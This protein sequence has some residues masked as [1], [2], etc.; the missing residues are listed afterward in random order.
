MNNKKNLL[1][2]LD[3]TLISAEPTTEYDFK[4]NKRKAKK[5]TFHNMDDYYI[6]FERPGLQEF[7]K[8]V[9]EKYNVS[10]WTAA[11]KEYGL[12]IIEKIL[13]QNKPERKL[14]FIMFSYHCD[15]SEKKGKGLKDLGILWKK[16][17]LD[18]YNESNT[19]IIDDNN[20]VSEIN[21]D[22]CIHIKPFK[23]LDKNSYK[24]KELYNL[25]D[26]L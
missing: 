24:D 22:R 16:F 10:V 11:S 15:I 17:K 26:K 18:G 3:E 2:D 13:L 7:L 25:V 23:F 6:V 5:F 14:D 8:Y 1:L 21:K 9:F 19:V 12:F 4:K 20:E